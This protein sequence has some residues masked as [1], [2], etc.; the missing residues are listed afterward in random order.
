MRTL[1]LVAVLVVSAAH[2]QT[3]L[4]VYNQNFAAVKE[5]RTFDLSQGEN[6]SARD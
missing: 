5:N 1:P 2:A 3:Q 4:T 6:E